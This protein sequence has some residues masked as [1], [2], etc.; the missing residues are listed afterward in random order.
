[1]RRMLGLVL[2]AL[3]ISACESTWHL[4]PVQGPLATQSP[5]LILTATLTR[6]TEPP[7]LQL[8]LP[9]GESCRGSVAQVL[10][11]DPAARSMSTVWDA[12]YGSG[13]F[14][15]HVLGSTLLNGGQLTGTQGTTLNVQFLQVPGGIRGVASDN[16]GNVFKLLWP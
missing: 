8:T 6:Q 12:V 7:T 14:V 2:L 1:M 13:F 11:T 3:S 9:S 15:A 5:S 16:Q 10:P 4:Y